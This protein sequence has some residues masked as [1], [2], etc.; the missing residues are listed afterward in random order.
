MAA[1]NE[2]IFS[3]RNAVEEDMTKSKLLV[4][5]QFERE[6]LEKTLA[7][8]S[9]AQK[10]VP[11]VMEA[12][13]VKDLLA[14]ITVWEQRM[15]RWLEQTVRDEVPEMLPPGMTWDDLD[16]W[17]EQTYQKHRHRDL[18][19]VLADFELSY[20]QALSAVQDISEEDLIDPDR[21]AWRDGRPLWEMVAA[22]TSWHYKEHEETITTWLKGLD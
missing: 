19:E 16:Q 7:K 6:R 15:L 20:P 1:P 2:N 4:E 21:Y 13:T 14:H 10:L 17:N 5:I 3:R 8:I 9:E 11:G 12:W 18:D 22:N